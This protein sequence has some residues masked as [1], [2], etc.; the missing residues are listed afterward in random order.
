MMSFTAV[1]ELATLVAYVVM[2]A[3]GREKREK[4]WKVLVFMLVLVGVLQCACMS[5]VVCLALP[6]IPP[7]R[8]GIDI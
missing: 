3:G 2:I 6:P 4:G 1:M 8:I 5:I 7:I